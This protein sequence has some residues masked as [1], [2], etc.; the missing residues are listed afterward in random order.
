MIWLVRAAITFQTLL[1]V[2]V[3]MSDIATRLISNKLC[4]MIAAVGIGC[5]L[6]VEPRLLP[7]SVIVAAALF[8]LLLLLHCRGWIGGGDVKLLVSLSI[9]LPIFQVIPFLVITTWVGGVLAMV[10]LM[11]R[12][13]PYPTRP[14]IGSSR[15][16]RI[17]AV[18][19]WR[20]LR[21]APLPYGI[22]IA[23]SGIWIILN[24]GA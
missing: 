21:H 5:H 24:H 14:P 15:L 16:R 1:L 3:I 10:H 6:L 22:A 23:C 9:G 18:E 7:T 13:L 11:M 19:R 20:N 8:L 17:Y 12:N 4:L 2:C